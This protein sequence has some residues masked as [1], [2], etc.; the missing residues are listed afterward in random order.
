MVINWPNFNII[1]PQGR[2]RPE[3]RQKDQEMVSGAVRT[4]ST[5]TS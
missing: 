3:E 2:R 1:V 5:F 4:H